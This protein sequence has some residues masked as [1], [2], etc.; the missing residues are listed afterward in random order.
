[1]LP[2]YLSPLSVEVGE[3]MYPRFENRGIIA[4]P[5]PL[6]SLTPQQ[7]PE[8]ILLVGLN[9]PRRICHLPWVAGEQ[10]VEGKALKPL[11]DVLP[12]LFLKPK[13]AEHYFVNLS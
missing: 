8:A 13:E 7:L 9:P 6:F 10:L 4:P 1:M 12:L 2:F 5:H 11:E 3:S